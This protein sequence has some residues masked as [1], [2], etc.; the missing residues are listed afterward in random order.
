MQTIILFGLYSLFYNKKITY[1]D[2]EFIVS[3]VNLFG[4][5]RTTYSYKDINIVRDYCFGY[6]VRAKEETIV[7]NFC[8][9]KK[10]E[11]SNFIKYIK[12]NQAKN[13][14]KT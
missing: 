14:E 12:Q 8:E 1:N 10:Q 5:T 2:E 9:Y 11:V 4:A 13:F 3:S 6:S 7:L